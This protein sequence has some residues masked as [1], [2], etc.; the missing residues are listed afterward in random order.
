MLG[1][2]RGKENPEE[3]ELGRYIEML[4]AIKKEMDLPK[5]VLPEMDQLKEVLSAKRH[6]RPL[7]PNLFQALLCHMFTPPPHSSN[8]WHQLSQK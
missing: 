4:Q 2:L 6:T 7:L 1:S 5:P 3:A 8:L